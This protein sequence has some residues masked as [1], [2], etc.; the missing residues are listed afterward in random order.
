M[1]FIVAVLMVVPAQAHDEGDSFAEILQRIVRASRE[2]FRPVQGARIE[3]H[4]G[5]I[6]YYQPKVYLPGTTECRIEERPRWIYSCQ[7]HGARC[8]KLRADTESALGPQ[9]SRTG[10]TFKHK[11]RF[12]FTEVTVTPTCAIAVSVLRQYSDSP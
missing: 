1:R 11:G 7:W 12:R 4:P 9:W 8:E 10:S 3:M 2:N 6:S 5:N